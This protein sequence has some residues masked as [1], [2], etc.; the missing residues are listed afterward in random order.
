M[1]RIEVSLP[2]DVGGNFTVSAVSAAPRT[3]PIVAEMTL[4]IIV[5]LC[6]WCGKP[7]VPCREVH[8][9]CKDPNCRKT[10]SRKRDREYEPETGG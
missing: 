3:M 5:K 4:Q 2:P 6:A 9:F 7:F 10:A 8:R 1:L